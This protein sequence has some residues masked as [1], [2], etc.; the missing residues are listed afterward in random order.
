MA[1]ALWEEFYMSMSK[2]TGVHGL[3][4]INKWTIIKCYFKRLILQKALILHI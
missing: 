3:I 1:C 4:C 2:T